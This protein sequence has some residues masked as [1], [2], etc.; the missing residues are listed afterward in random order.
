MAG[1]WMKWGLAGLVALVVAYAWIDGGQADLREF[2]MAVR[3]P[4][5]GA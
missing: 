1:K 5:N 4:G 3:V 2:R